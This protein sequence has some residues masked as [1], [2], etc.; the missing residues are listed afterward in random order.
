MRPVSVLY[1]T[2]MKKN[3]VLVLVL[4]LATLLLPSCSSLMGDRGKPLTADEDRRLHTRELTSIERERFYT[5]RQLTPEQ[6]A[7]LDDGPPIYV[8]T[9]YGPIMVGGNRINMDS[10]RAVH[11]QQ[12]GLLGESLTR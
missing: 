3:T 10:V 2:S 7:V 5:E 8:Q 1:S 6:Q 12:A 11:A 9:D 4:V